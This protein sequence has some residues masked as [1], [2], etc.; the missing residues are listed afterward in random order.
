MVALL[1]NSRE[2]RPLMNVRCAPQGMAATVTA[3]WLSMTIAGCAAQPAPLAPSPNAGPSAAP[4][5]GSG[6]SMPPGTSAGAAHARP[7]ASAAAFPPGPLPGGEQ[8]TP[9]KALP[10]LR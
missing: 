7:G 1:G 6:D 5:G 9:D 3:L 2:N 4:A 10:E 8:P